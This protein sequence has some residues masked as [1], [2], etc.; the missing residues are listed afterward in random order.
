MI[1]LGLKKETIGASSTNKHQKKTAN[2]NKLTNYQSA[3][4]TIA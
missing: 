3:L 1:L 2:S 4:F